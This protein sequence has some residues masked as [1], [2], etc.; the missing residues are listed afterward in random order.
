[1][2]DGTF[3]K[4]LYYRM[5]V[6]TIH[7]PPL[8]ERGDD[9]PLLAE[10][11]LKRF[12]GKYGKRVFRLGDAA[13]AAL[14]QYPWPGNVR[15]L[16]HVIERAVLSAPPDLTEITTL[17]LGAAPPTPATPALRPEVPGRAPEFPS[18][19]KSLAEWERA[20]I[21]RALREAGGNQVRAAKLLGISRD[22]LRYRMAKFKISPQVSEGTQ[23]G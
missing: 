20:M 2:A 18:T 15:E 12:G 16:K 6:L 3:R 17:A 8:R 14:C 4:D 13:V 22:T 23:T 9:V 5:A 21:E 11:F 7:L 10:F 1:M 19:G